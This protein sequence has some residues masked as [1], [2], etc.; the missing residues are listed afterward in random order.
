MKPKIEINYSLKFD[1]TKIKPSEH[2]DKLSEVTKLD[3]LK[4]AI[5]L[6]TE[7]YNKTLENWKK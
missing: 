4:D 5:T 2:F 1:E 3:I 7:F 6:L